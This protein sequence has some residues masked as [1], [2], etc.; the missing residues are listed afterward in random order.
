MCTLETGIYMIVWNNILKR[1]DDP[2]KL[3]QDSTL[4]LNTAVSAIKS[5]NNFVQAKRDN[6]D[7][8]EK[9]EADISETTDYLKHHKRQSD[10]L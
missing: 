2:N 6:F 1:V 5:L 4:D 3:L 10:I 8:Y 7:Q 9:Q